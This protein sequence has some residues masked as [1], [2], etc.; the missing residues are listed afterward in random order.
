LSTIFFPRTWVDYAAHMPP[1]DGKQH[2]QKSKL[3]GV[4]VADLLPFVAAGP[5][6]VW[7]GRHR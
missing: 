5:Q 3:S 4:G 2:P 7:H 6:G 1:T